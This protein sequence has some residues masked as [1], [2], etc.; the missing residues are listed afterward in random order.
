MNA[1]LNI[2]MVNTSFPIFTGTCQYL[3]FFCVRNFQFFFLLLRLYLYNN[4]HCRVSDSR[5]LL[6]FL[7]LFLTRVHAHNHVIVSLITLAN[8]CSLPYSLIICISLTLTVVQYERSTVRCRRRRLIPV[9][10]T[11]PANNYIYIYTQLAPTNSK[12]TLSNVYETR[13]AH[14]LARGL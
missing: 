7:A 1:Y 9:T 10:P 6:S 8:S 3:P 11:V 13:S 14:A 2:P 12:N 4:V 5:M